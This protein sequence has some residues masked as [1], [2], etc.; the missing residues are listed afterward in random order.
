MEHPIQIITDEFSR[1]ASVDEGTCTEPK[2][3]SFFVAPFRTQYCTTS[4]RSV[5]RKI[6]LPN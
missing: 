2:V 1:I 3:I 4:F 5:E 6:K